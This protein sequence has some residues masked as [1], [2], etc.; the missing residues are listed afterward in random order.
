[1]QNRFN[2]PEIP[3]LLWKRTLGA[4]SNGTRLRLGNTVRRYFIMDLVMKHVKD[5]I[6]YLDKNVE[7]VRTL[8]GHYD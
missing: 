6:K 5:K 1:M 8:I 4:F 2:K 3:S 7:N